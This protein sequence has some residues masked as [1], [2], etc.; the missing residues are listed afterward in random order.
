[1]NRELTTGVN[2][3]SAVT[4][5]EKNPGEIHIRPATLDDTEALASLS[6]QLGYPATP[7][8][9]A[10]RLRSWASLP[11]HAVFV[12]C[13]PTGEVAAFIDLGITHH[14]QIDPYV[15]IG[16][17]VVD[18]SA[19]NR[20]IG[21]RLLEQAESWA[22]AHRIATIRVRSN[23]IRAD[24]HRFYERENYVREKTSAVF[25]KSVPATAEDAS[26]AWHAP[27]S[28]ATTSRE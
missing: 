4:T 13:L 19:R 9:I 14:L 24:A 22:R 11:H 16:G 2:K 23:V 15:E 28:S 1:M 12:A 18:A 5:E 26:C 27:S 20:G 21:V 6:T 8:L 7:Q 17:L 25:R 10:E 3:P